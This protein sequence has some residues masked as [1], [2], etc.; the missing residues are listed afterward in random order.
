MSANKNKSLKNCTKYYTGIEFNKLYSN[1]WV[2]IVNR[3]RY[4]FIDIHGKETLNMIIWEIDK[5]LL[6]LETNNG[7]DDKWY[8]IWKAKVLNNNGIVTIMN[9]NINATN[10]FISLNQ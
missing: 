2:I 1:N 5:A 4:S 7:K 9:D 8:T 6:W 10:L 3:K